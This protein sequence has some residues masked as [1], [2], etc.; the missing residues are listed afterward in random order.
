MKS[1]L[2]GE[3]PL[4]YFSKYKHAKY[5]MAIMHADIVVKPLMSL[6]SV[7]HPFTPFYNTMYIYTLQVHNAI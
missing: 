5:E 6:H 3:L 2:G 1:E 4:I 7:H